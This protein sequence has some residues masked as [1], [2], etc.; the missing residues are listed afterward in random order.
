M[1]AENCPT[2]TNASNTLILFGI[3]STPSRVRMR[4]AIRSTWLN[5]QNWKF[6]S[7]IEVHSI[8]LLGHEADIFGL[9]AESE[10]YKDLVQSDFHES[11]Y[12]L[13]IKDHDFFNFIVEQC[14]HLDFAVKGDDDVLIVPQ[15]LAMLIEKLNLSRVIQ[16]RQI[17]HSRYII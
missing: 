8:F 15:N 11:H 3:K 6:D 5:R 16:M 12:N 7:R 9:E 14:P 13:S 17:C 4:S 2:K 10:I 1:K